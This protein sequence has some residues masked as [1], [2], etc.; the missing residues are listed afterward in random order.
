[1][2]ENANQIK[3]YIYFQYTCFSKILVAICYTEAYERIYLAGLI[4]CVNQNMT[5]FCNPSHTFE[6]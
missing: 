5:Q 1:L 3:T 6:V 4:A 2:V